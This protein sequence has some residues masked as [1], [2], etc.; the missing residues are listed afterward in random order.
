MSKRFIDTDIWEKEWF[1][2]LPIEEKLAFKFIC[3]RCSLIGIW[4]PNYFL[5]ETMIGKKVDWKHLLE[6]CNGNIE[7]L[8]SG[9]FW[10]VNFCFFQY[11]K[12]TEDCKPHR[13]YISL[14]KEEGL[15]ER[16]S[17]GY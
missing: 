9:K 7:E 1:M 12:L 17:K 15:Y 11:G 4:S 10:V 13:K 8:S 16:V 2:R 14:L 5:A 3:E 6:N